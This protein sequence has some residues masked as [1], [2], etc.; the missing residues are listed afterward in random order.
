MSLHKADVLIVISGSVTSKE[1][2][3]SLFAKSLRFPKYFG[4]NWD[5]LYDC[6]CDLSWLDSCRIVIIHE[7]PFTA[8]SGG[9]KELYFSTLRDAANRWKSDEGRYSIEVKFPND[10]A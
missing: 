10:K 6:L 9:D 5:A 3:L 7:D 2:L 4:S 1:D 8:L